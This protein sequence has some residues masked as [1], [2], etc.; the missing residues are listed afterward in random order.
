MQLCSNCSS[1]CC[2]CQCTD[3]ALHLVRQ[4]LKVAESK[5]ASA[6]ACWASAARRTSSMTCLCSSTFSEGS[7]VDERL[8]EHG[9][10]RKAEMRV[11]LFA[12]KPGV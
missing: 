10:L 8:I 6:A 4:L 11:H 1:C 7:H 2:T 3:S 5:L 12:V 9:I